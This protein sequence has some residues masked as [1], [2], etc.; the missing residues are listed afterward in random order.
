MKT[1]TGCSKLL[2]KFCHINNL[3]LDIETFKESKHCVASVLGRYGSTVY[4]SLEPASKTTVDYV[5]KRLMRFS[6]DGENASDGENRLSSEEAAC[7]AAVFFILEASSIVYYT[8][9]RH[10]K[11]IDVSNV[12][13][14]EQLE[15][16]CDLVA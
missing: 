14:T 16:L 9:S 13:T 12:T 2:Q 5:A 15:I 11:W 4:F 10:W 8:S 3:E 6:S 7:R 1:K